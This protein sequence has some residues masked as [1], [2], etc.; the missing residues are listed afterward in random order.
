MP[1]ARECV[2]ELSTQTL[3]SYS[4]FTMLK[5]TPNSRPCVQ[6]RSASLNLNWRNLS[7][8]RSKFFRCGCWWGPS[9]N[10]LC[11]VKTPTSSNIISRR[12][13]TVVM[14]AWSFHQSAALVNL[15]FIF[16]FENRFLDSLFIKSKV[17]TKSTP[18]KTSG[19]VYHSATKTTAVLCALKWYTR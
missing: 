19:Y 14:H 1:K 12:R 5:L 17:V 4:S 9:Y 6:K 10:T 13:T 7:G 16:I 8:S 18:R 3:P 15:N 11:T 2:I